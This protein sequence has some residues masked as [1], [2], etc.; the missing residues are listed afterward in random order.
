MIFRVLQNDGGTIQNAEKVAPARYIPPRLTDQGRYRR[1]GREALLA[2][3]RIRDG[4]VRARNYD[5]AGDVAR[6]LREAR[7]LFTSAARLVLVRR[8]AAMEV[9]S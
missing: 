9:C 8:A 7:W 3:R 5:V 2:A 4:V 6:H 1:E